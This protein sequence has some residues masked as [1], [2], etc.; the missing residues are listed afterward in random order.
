MTEDATNHLIE[1]NGHGEA[2]N[3]GHAHDDSHGL[4]MLL[5]IVTMI[6]FFIA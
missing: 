3:G 5:F 2:E 1:A 4:F 6:I